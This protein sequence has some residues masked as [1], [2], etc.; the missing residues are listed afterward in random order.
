MCLAAPHNFGGF[1]AVR[2]FLGFAEGAVQPA[3]VTLTSIWYKKREHP[4]RVGYVPT[5]ICNTR[6][7]ITIC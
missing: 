6:D 3:A 7:R 4:Q 1:S 5:I 2:F